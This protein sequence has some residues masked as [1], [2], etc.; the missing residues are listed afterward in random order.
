MGVF[1]VHCTYSGVPLSGDVQVILMQ[2][3]ADGWT[4]LSAPFRSTY[5]RYGAID[6]PDVPAFAA[7]VKWMNEVSSVDNAAEAFETMRGGAATWQG[8]DLHYALVDAAVYDALPEATSSAD[9]RLPA[10]LQVPWKTAIAGTGPI[11]LDTADQY[12][13]YAGDYGARAAIDRARAKFADAPAVRAA[14]EKNAA[15]WAKIDES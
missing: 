2:R 11:D 5:D 13:G 12:T 3:T 14:I 7:F 1:D 10:A 8:A 9:T 4:P 15:R 6:E